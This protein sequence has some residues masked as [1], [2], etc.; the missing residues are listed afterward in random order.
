MVSSALTEAGERYLPNRIVK[1]DRAPTIDTVLVGTGTTPASVSD[2]NLDSQIHAGAIPADSSIEANNTVDGAIDISIEI[3]GG[4]E[5]PP[6]TEITELGFETSD[7]DFI[8]REVREGTTVAGGER[9]SFSVSLR[10]RND[11]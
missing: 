10:I 7:G 9:L 6:N 2:T 8:Y 5:V 3:T 11:R 1:G 4:I